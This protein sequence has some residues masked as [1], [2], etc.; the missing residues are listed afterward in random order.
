[1]V[2]IRLLDFL[3]NTLMSRLMIPVIHPAYAAHLVGGSP[4]EFPADRT[5]SETC[6]E[7]V[8]DNYAHKPIHP[9]AIRSF[10]ERLDHKLL[11]L[12]SPSLHDLLRTRINY[13]P[14]IVLNIFLLP[15][16][17]V[18]GHSTRGQRFQ[19]HSNVDFWPTCD[20]YMKIWN[21]NLDEFLH[22]LKHPFP[23]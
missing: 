12:R 13:R 16:F 20:T 11:V 9:H 2:S 17:I 6:F 1:M 23:R 18:K 22:K 4:G 3:Q 10:R 5:P 8:S 21:A 19:H 7:I 15:T 14:H